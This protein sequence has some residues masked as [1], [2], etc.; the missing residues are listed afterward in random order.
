[1][2]TSTTPLRRRHLAAAG[3][4]AAALVGLGGVPSESRAETSTAGAPSVVVPVTPFRLLD[5]RTGVGAGGRTDPLGPDSTITVQVAGVGT[6]PTDATG[7]ILNVTAN[8]ATASGYVTAT[9][10]GSPRAE[11]SVLNLTPGQDLPNM[12]TATLGTGGRLDLYNFTGSVHLI[13]D[14]A[15]YLIPAGASGSGPAG[16]Q[17]PAGPAGPSGFAGVHVVLN[18]YIMKAGDTVASADTTCPDG[19][20]I[21]GGGVATFNNNIQIMVNS[22]LADGGETGPPTRWIMSARTFNGMPVNADSSINIRI[23]CAI[24]P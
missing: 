10:T 17:G 22:P 16:P 24:A 13:A 11:T 14:V 23:L 12:V 21:V 7:V 3:L 15:G 5:T 4:V 18:P 8:A 6:I 2:Q 20:V 19:E 1:M 9:P